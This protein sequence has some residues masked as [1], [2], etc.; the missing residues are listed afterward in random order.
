MRRLALLLPLLALSACTG[1]VEETPLVGLAVLEDGGATLTR[2]QPQRAAGSAAGSAATWTTT[3][4]RGVESGRDLH[5]IN[6]GRGVVLVRA[7]AAERLDV[8]LTSVQTFTL[9][10]VLTTPCFI[11]SAQSA[12]RDRLLLLSQ[13]EETNQF[14]A[15]YRPDGSLVWSAL[16]P[17]ATPPLPGPDT[18]PL[19][20][21]VEGDVAVVSR[22]ALGGGSEVVRVAPRGSGDPARDLEGLVTQPQASVAI[23]DLAAVGAELYA[24]TDNGVRRVLPSGLPDLENRVTALGERRYDRLWGGNVGTRQLLAAWRDTALSGNGTEPLYLW[25]TLR[26]DAATV[27]LA[28]GLRDLTFSPDGFLYTLNSTS[29][30]RYNLTLGLQSGNWQ[31]AALTR[32]LQGARAMTWLLP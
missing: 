11:Q 3:R 22:P 19:R 17:I 31:E 13:C 27:T 28:A 8:A 14:A 20:L 2:L 10:P 26:T 6:G 4:L 23:R 5:T 1:T 12:A 15:L 25:D 32:Q 30:L 18:P 24:A 21:A 29:V 16:L 7:G 9:P